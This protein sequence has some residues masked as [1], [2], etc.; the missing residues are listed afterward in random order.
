ML[1][2]KILIETDE[3]TTVLDAAKFLGVHFATVYRWIKAGRLL[4]IPIGGQVYLHTSE[5]K[6]L[7][8][9]TN[10]AQE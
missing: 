4:G 8:N 9:K 7:K 2:V 1:K 6:A 5:V 10:E 3:L